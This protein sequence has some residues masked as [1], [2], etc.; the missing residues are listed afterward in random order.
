ML[1]C[2]FHLSDWNWLRSRNT[3]CLYILPSRSTTRSMLSAAHANGPRIPIRLS[4]KQSRNSGQDVVHRHCNRLCDTVFAS[5]HVPSEF[6]YASTGTECRELAK[7][8]LAIT[9]WPGVVGGATGFRA[10]RSLFLQNVYVD[11]SDSVY[12]MATN[13]SR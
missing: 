8:L 7:I 13:T 4:T 10:V 12:S 6:R 11:G 2:R 3:I 1:R 9:A 5:L